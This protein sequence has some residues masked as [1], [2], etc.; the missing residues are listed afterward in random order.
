MFGSKV[1]IG[2]GLLAV[3]CFG[4][5]N[6]VIIDRFDLI[7]VLVAAQRI[8]QAERTQQTELATVEIRD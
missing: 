4:L 6:V 8:V 3:D 5:V 2:M 1:N 7:A